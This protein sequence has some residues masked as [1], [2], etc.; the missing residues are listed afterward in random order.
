VV[1]VFVKLVDFTLPVEFNYLFRIYRFT[2][3]PWMS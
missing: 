2:N 3:G 1:V